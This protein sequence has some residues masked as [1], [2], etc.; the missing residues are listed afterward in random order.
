MSSLNTAKEKS[1]VIKNSTINFIK[2]IKHY[3]RYYFTFLLITALLVI[4][5]ILIVYP[6]E[7]FSFPFISLSP[8][9]TMLITINISLFALSITIYAL[10]LKLT[11]GKVIGRYIQ[12]ELEINRICFS[13][14][15]FFILIILNYILLFSLNVFINLISEIFL[16][17]SLILSILFIL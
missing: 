6:S 12:N 17:I 1:V 16:I 2:K 15:S 9:F 3:F 7:F 11:E 13:F 5:D 8:I 14:V 10:I 4:G